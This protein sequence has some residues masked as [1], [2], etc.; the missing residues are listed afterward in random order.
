MYENPV[1]RP[2]TSGSNTWKTHVFLWSDFKQS[3]VSWID[4]N[5]HQ[6]SQRVDKPV[7]VARVI[8]EEVQTLQPFIL[9][10]LLNVSAKCFTPT[11]EFKAQRQIVLENQTI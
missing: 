9:D 11:S 2:N 6:H 3:V 1:A 8:T 10:N 4:G 5:H 7:F